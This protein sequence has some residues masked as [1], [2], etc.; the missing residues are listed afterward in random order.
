MA[1]IHPRVLERLQQNRDAQLK[2]LDDMKR[3]TVRD[4]ERLGA[5][6]QAV[7]HEMGL[8]VPGDIDDELR[9]LIRKVTEISPADPELIDSLQD[10]SRRLSAVKEAVEQKFRL[11]CT[12]SLN[13]SEDD[14]CE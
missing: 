5:A 8:D 1:H 11:K 14:G 7:S 9:K 4:I 10:I 6:L 12:F 2:L 3:K 13:I